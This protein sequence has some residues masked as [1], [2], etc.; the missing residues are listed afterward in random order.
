[1][2]DLRQV[3]GHLK[4]MNSCRFFFILLGCVWLSLADAAE[5]TG[6]TNVLLICVDDLKP[7]LGCYGAQV[8]SPNIDRLADGSV[9]FAA[10]YANQAVCAPSRNSLMTGRRPTSLG[11][12]DLSTFFREAAPDAI[13]L[14]QWF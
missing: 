5:S 3:S 10:A 13:T 7:L 8:R 6:R 12:Y 4:I 2:L 9:R 11:I 14:A 1:M